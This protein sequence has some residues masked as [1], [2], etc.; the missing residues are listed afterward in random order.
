MKDPTMKTLWLALALVLALAL[1]AGAS[2][3]TLPQDR[4]VP[5]VLDAH[6]NPAKIQP[7]DSWVIVDA[8]PYGACSAFVIQKNDV[9]AFVVING[10]GAD[11]PVVFYI[12][13]DGQSVAE[14]AGSPHVCEPKG[15][16][17]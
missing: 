16:T 5:L 1:P 2:H 12:I 14:W 13:G 4:Q 10:K 17:I 9:F 8:G 11:A 7:E 15:P 3:E 6:G